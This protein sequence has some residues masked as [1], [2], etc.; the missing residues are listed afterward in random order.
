MNVLIILCILFFFAFLYGLII[1][2]ININNNKDLVAWW[3]RQ[4]AI[5]SDLQNK[6][7]INGIPSYK[8]PSS[9]GYI[10]DIHHAIDD[11]VDEI[12]RELIDVLSKNNYSKYIDTSCLHILFDGK[13]SSNNQ[14]QKLY[15]NYSILNKSDSHDV[16]GDGSMISV[17]PD[18]E[19]QN[20]QVDGNHQNVQVNINHQNGQVDINH[21]NEQVDA[22][23]QNGQVNINYQ[24]EQVDANHQNGQMNINHQNDLYED[25]YHIYDDISLDNSEYFNGLNHL[26]NSKKHMLHLKKMQNDVFTEHPHWN[27]IWVKYMGKITGFG[28]KLKNMIP[29]ASDKNIIN[30]FISVLNPNCSIIEHQNSFKGVIRYQYNLKISSTDDVGCS[31]QHHAMRWRQHEGLMWD[32]TLKHTVWNHGNSPQ[33]IICIDV[34]RPLGY[35]LD[36]GNRL[37]VNMLQHDHYTNELQTYFQEY[38]VLDDPKVDDLVV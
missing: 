13:T 20:G 24:N 18:I 28:H 31:I 32:P 9:C 3:N 5:S 4:I 33:I 19:H 1:F 15:N 34:H 25:T 38:T 2:K 16:H 26:N 29:I 11:D 23:H 22:N 27:M 36:M 14:P 12:Y 30:M 35:I 17:H 10:N 37:V 6:N 7:S 8:H 21:Q